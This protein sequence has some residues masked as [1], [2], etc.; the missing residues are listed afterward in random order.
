MRAHITKSAVRA[1][2]RAASPNPV[3]RFR[4]T[5]RS[6]LRHT[7]LPRESLGRPP[8]PG[9][10]E[11]DVMARSALSGSPLPQ[12]R[13]GFSGAGTLSPPGGVAVSPG[14]LLDR[15]T[16]QYFEPRFGHDFSG[17]RVHHDADAHAAAATL[18][19][20]AFTVGDHVFFGSERYA[21]HS[22]S[23]RALLAHELAHVVQQRQTGV[24]RVQRQPAQAGPARVLVQAGP[25]RR[26]P[27]KWGPV[28]GGAVQAAQIDRI[29][30][31]VDQFEAT[32]DEKQ[33]ITIAENILTEIE[34]LAAAPDTD[35]Q[36][37]ALL[38]SQAATLRAGLRHAKEERSTVKRA[39][40]AAGATV[41]VGGGPEDPAADV[42][43]G[44]VF[45]GVLIAGLFAAAPKP[46]LRQ[47]R[48]AVDQV[49]DSVARLAEQA[50]DVATAALMTAAGNV[51]HDHIVNEAKELAV[52]LGLAAT[53]AGVTREMVCDMLRRM[54]AQTRRTDTEKWKKIIAT[55]K[56][57]GCRHHR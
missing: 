44:V 9:E 42:V 15:Q 33:R 16:R 57:L 52:A 35:T 24:V 19:A 55:Q 23:G 14:S 45:F 6:H 37:E 48:E 8:E 7:G 2:D 54:A 28:Q 56:G 39:G 50:E 4:G 12:V 36:T 53:A 29:D 38:R 43:A 25:P 51:V 3:T 11:A 18:D 31:L 47:V 27:V 22:P 41:L 30:K 26:V 5:S 1:T 49:K 40:M 32:S 20:S 34:R 10:A 13:H 17:V 21:P 46:D